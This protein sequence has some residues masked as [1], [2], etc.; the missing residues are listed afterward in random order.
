M[1]F[2]LK[3]VSIVFCAGIF[4]SAFSNFGTDEACVILAS[5]LGF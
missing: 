5:L 4:L 2:A 1:L 3:V